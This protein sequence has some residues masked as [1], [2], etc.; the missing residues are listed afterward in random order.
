VA[1]CGRCC[2]LTLAYAQLLAATFNNLTKPPQTEAA[3][4]FN[5][6]SRPMSDVCDGTFARRID[7]YCHGWVVGAA[8]VKPFVIDGRLGQQ[9]S[10][11]S[12]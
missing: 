8:T 4:A 10:E 3:P 12:C 1:Q 6:R 11:P 7:G 5:A 2:R 9:A